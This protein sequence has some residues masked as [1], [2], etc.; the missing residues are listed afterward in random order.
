MTDTLH[1]ELESAPV[2]DAHA[3][4]QRAWS[5]VRAATPLADARKRTSRRRGVIV[6]VAA[7]ATVGTVAAAVASGAPVVEWVKQRMDPAP[8]KP[9]PTVGP[10][11]RLPAPGRLLVRPRNGGLVLINADGT[12]RRLG[13]YAGASWSPRRLYIVVW[14]AN[15]LSAIT[16]DGSV[17]WQHTTPGR[18][19][20]ARWSPDGYRIA[21]TT[22]NGQLRVIAGD[23]TGDR[24][25]LSTP[26]GAAVPAWRPT[27][28]HTLAYLSQPGRLI[29][30]N[31]DT[32]AHRQLGHRIT[33]AVRTMSWS[34]GGRLLSTTS[35]H[36][37]RTYNLRTGGRAHS[38]ARP[39]S[40]YV[41]ATFAPG[42]PTLA[43]ITTTGKRSTLTAAN[44]RFTTQG[45]IASATWSPN[46]R[47][48]L[49]NATD[50]EQ[51]IAIRI[52]GTPRVQSYPGANVQDWSG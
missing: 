46:G 35:P 11:R 7:L 48:L 44:Q 3:A 43:R 32:G 45:R 21:Y 1:R 27:E 6:A 29:V 14:R 52:V 4:Q 2:P 30:Q 9:Q 12:R 41:D 15:Q 13:I 18:V 25:L 33:P 38:R 8:T 51:L 42:H 20:A 16:P 36:Q 17:R 49:L 40:R 19:R 22:R 28:A 5:T 50:A 26:V 34:S 47:W 31:V 24:R 23:G 10:A 37:L 39:R